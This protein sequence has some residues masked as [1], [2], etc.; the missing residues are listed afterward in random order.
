MNIPSFTNFHFRDTFHQK[1]FFAAAS[2]W[3]LREK[4]GDNKVLDVDHGGTHRK[5]RKSNFSFKKK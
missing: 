3:L 4:R 5:E 1:N 2:C